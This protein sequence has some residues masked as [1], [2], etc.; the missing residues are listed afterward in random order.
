MMHNAKFFHIFIILISIF[1]N[2]K[3]YKWNMQ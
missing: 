2:K 1:F 3:N